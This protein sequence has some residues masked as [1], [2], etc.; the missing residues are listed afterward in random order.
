M[1]IMPAMI[2][3]PKSYIWCSKNKKEAQMGK[4]WGYIKMISMTRK[5]HIKN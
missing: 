4:N 1:N 3:K 5:H 2:A